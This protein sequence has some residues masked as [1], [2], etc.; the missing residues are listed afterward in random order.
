MLPSLKLHLSRI[1]FLILA[2][3]L[4][5][6]QVKPERK[7]CITIFF[8]DIVGF[9]TISTILTDEQ[10]SDMLDRLYLRLDDLTHEHDIF[11]IE[12]IGDAYMCATNLVKSQ[13]DD[14][15]KRIAKFSFDALQAASETLVSLANPGMGYIRM[16]I[17]FHSG[18]V[19]ARVVGSRLPKFAIFGDAVNTASRM[20]SNSLPGKIQCSD[21]TAEILKKQCP[22]MK[23]VSRGKIQVKGKDD[24]ETF[25]VER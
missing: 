12:T 23:I 3:V 15:A 18:P 13:D 17:G 25:F 5:L 20:E 14:H 9:T 16:R 10:V 21:F 1:S 4:S 22:E 19:I 11:K 24:M 7:D 2:L 8:S 6:L